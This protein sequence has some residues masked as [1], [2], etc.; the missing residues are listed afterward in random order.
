MPVLNFDNEYDREGLG[1]ANT[2]P[3]AAEKL[4]QNWGQF[5]LRLTSDD[6][7]RLQNG[8]V[9]AVSVE[10]FVLCIMSIDK[11]PVPPEPDV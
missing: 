7:I 6:I 8:E 4:G 10:E 3:N 9:L 1:F 5:E 2:I 11:Y